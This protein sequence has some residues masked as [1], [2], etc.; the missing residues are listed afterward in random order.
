MIDVVVNDKETV[1]VAVSRNLL[2]LAKRFEKPEPKTT[3]ERR[4]TMKQFH[5]PTYELPDVEETQDEEERR[6]SL[7]ANPRK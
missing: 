6:H 7:D 5:L 2:G 4:A 1:A 3:K